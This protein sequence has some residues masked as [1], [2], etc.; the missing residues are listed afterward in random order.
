MSEE[1]NFVRDLAVILISAGVLTVVSKALKQPLV[2]GYIIAGFLVGPH[3]SFFP[4][5]TSVEEVH[6]WSEIGMVFMMF[7]L[8]LE[9]SLKKLLSVGSTA[10]MVAGLKFIGV[11][12]I[13]FL[14]GLV[15]GWTVMESIFLAGLLS[16][17]STAVVIKAYDDMGLKDSP[18][19]P[20][21]FGTLVVEDLIAV[22]LMVLF[23]TMAVSN[24]ISGT[25]LGL[26]ILKIVFFLALWFL[27]G[28]YVIPSLLRWARQWLTDE[29]LLIVAIGLCFL[30]VVVANSVGFSS[31][32]GAFVMGSILAET[33]EGEHIAHL[34]EGIKNLFSAIFFVS[35]GMMLDPAI[36]ARYWAV[37]LVLSVIVI[38]SHF[39]FAGGGV[40]LA[41]KGLNKAVNTGLSLS[42]LGEFGFILA[43]VGVS[44]GALRGFIYPVIIAVSVI[45]TF[46]T[47]YVIKSSSLVINLMRRFLPKRFIARIDASERLVSKSGSTAQRSEWEHMIRD[48]SIRIFLY[49]IAL[50]AVMLL[51]RNVLPSLAGR[52]L[53]GWSESARGTVVFIVTLA[54]MIPF[55]FGMLSISGSFR[56]SVGRII[57][58]DSRNTWPVLMLLILKVFIPVG[59][60]ISLVSQHYSLPGWAMAL[61]VLLLFTL[62][63]TAHKRLRGRLNIERKFLNNLNAREDEARRQNPLTASIGKS[64][65]S[66]DV[67]IQSFEIGPDSIYA[68][69]KIK[70][71]PFREK[72]GVNILDIKRGGSNIPIPAGTERIF[73]GDTVLVA[74]T[75]EQISA[76]SA[77]LKEGVDHKPQDRLDFTVKPI[78]LTEQSPLAGHSLRSVDMRSAGCMVVS[79]L[80]GNDFTPNPPAD[81]HFEP[82]DVVWIAGEDRNCEWFH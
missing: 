4:G 20:L 67:H 72:T 81:Y 39:A 8:G 63:F 76:F 78:T 73:P 50:I 51:H 28:I 46:T 13:G 9:F 45:T 17:S 75:S 10:M 38:L 15:L 33:V 60:I 70:N 58:A 29:I 69:H 77:L 7:A 54:L 79:V 41:G 65:S 74:G 26:G 25:Q 53:A 52:L 22:V 43:G 64:F 55:F 24:S 31:A 80:R 27:V 47:P 37:I 2:L 71:L 3:I 5:I 21:V 12:A 6:Q 19:A 1:L 34:V 30:M 61:L 48:Y 18:Q 42:Q 57:R 62:S 23:S 40:L 82:G 44:L 56:Q 59:F 11:F 66:Y 68:G 35:V 14:L 32:L 49:S 36:I 16:M